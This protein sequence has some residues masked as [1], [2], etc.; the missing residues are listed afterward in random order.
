MVRGRAPRITGA[1]PTEPVQRSR[2]TQRIGEP[3]S[4]PRR[5]RRPRLRLSVRVA[6]TLEVWFPRN[7]FPGVCSVC[8]VFATFRCFL[9]RARPYPGILGWVKRSF[10]RYWQP[11]TRAARRGAGR[12][13]R[14]M[15]M[16]DSSACFVGTGN[17][18]RIRIK[19]GGQTS[20]AVYLPR[21]WARG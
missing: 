7:R 10:I 13:K 2:L 11:I 4:S 5:V 1:P 16:D 19:L 17:W 18:Q 6:A 20:I 14:G 15:D 12:S 3:A 9:F 8:C 21:A